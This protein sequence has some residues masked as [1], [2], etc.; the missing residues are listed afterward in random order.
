MSAFHT[1]TEARDLLRAKKLSSRELVQAAITRAETNAGTYITLTGEHALREATALDDK[2]A[3]GEDVGA[4]GGVPI[5][6]KDLFMT[7]GV[8]TTAASRMLE[9]FIA[10]YDATV[11]K[12]L[13]AAGAISIGKLN[14]DEFAMG[15]SNENSAFGPAHNP[16]DRARTPGGSSGGS[17][18]AVANGDVFATLGTDTGGSV[19]TPASFCGVVGIKPT[20]GRVSRYGV[21]A[22]ASSLDQVGPLARSVQDAALILQTI[23]G[24]DALDSTSYPSP[25][26]ASAEQTL[27]HIDLE[28]GVQGM[29][30]GVPKEYFITGMQ[31]EVEQAVRAAVLH[32]EK[33][34]AKIV[35]VSLP[36]TDYAIAAYYIIANA[37]ASANLARYD[38]VRYGRSTGREGGLLNMYEQTRGGGFGAEAKRRIMLG[39]YV[40]SAGYYDAY[41]VKAQ[42]VRTLLARDFAHAF[43]QCDALLAPVAPFTAFKLGEKSADPLQMYLTDVLTVSA[44]L[45]G[46]PALSLPCGFDAQGL[47]I[48]LQVLGKHWGE[49]TI[50]RAARAYERDTQ[51]HTRHPQ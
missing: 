16:W 35:Q 39:T 38:G 30:F 10:P 28:A 17:A 21:I 15:S 4:L 37:E 49:A 31:P 3:R 11:V 25:A 29:T 5:A 6:L 41:Y 1:L 43:E 12:K 42:K 40:L 22:F 23:A 36:H 9:S 2:R 33:L 44:N 7:E 27:A 51:W 13:R 47:P 8:R 46:L 32:Y 26:N 24:H 20:Y 34:G 19:R 48:G 14:M 45:A 50:L 18:A